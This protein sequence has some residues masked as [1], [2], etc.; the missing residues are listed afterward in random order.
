MQV[1]GQYKIRI[2]GWGRVR[3]GAVRR[4]VEIPSFCEDFYGFKRKARGDTGGL[5]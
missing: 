3:D 4:R 5:G 1:C 2:A